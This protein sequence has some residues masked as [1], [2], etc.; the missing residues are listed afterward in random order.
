V[1]RRRRL[2]KRHF[3]APREGFPTVTSRIGAASRTFQRAEET[4]LSAEMIAQPAEETF[5]SV[6]ASFQSAEATFRSAEAEVSV[7]SRRSCSAARRASGMWRG[8]DRVKRRSFG[9]RRD[10]PIRYTPRI[11]VMRPEACGTQV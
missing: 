6:E 11:D 9:R 3:R 1:S 7:C 10:E 5:Q 4:F 8:P 2:M